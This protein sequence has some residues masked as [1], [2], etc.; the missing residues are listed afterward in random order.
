M[1]IRNKSEI[2][3]IKLYQNQGS[4][5]CCAVR[6]FLTLADVPF[7]TVEVD[8]MTKSQLD[9]SHYKKV[10]VVTVNGLQINDSAIIIK[11]LAP[12]CYGRP[13]SD[14]EQIQVNETTT[15]GMLAFE[16]ELFSSDANIQ[17][18]LARYIKDDGCVTWLLKVL[19]YPY[20][21]LARF[22]AQSYPAPCPAP[23]RPPPR[24]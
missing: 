4:P 6:A 20:R 2:T 23:R 17:R 24:S 21:F 18:Y 1:P 16:V 13:L 7:E 14:I 19:G 9:F 3:K 22:F 8:Y 11:T 5:P 15:K 12:I 10:P